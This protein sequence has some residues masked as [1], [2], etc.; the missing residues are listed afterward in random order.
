MLAEKENIN[1]LSIKRPGF[2]FGKIVSQPHSIITA[3]DR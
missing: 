2:G 3:R 1:G